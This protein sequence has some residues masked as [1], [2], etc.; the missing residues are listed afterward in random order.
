MDAS[1]T[2]AL[3]AYSLAP[4]DRQVFRKFKAI[5]RLVLRESRLNRWAWKTFFCPSSVVVSVN[6]LAPS[7]DGPS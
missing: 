7:A 5:S 1:A 4:I 3:S 2:S 6:A